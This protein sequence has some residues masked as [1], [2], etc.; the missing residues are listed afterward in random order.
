L[1]GGFAGV[2]ARGLGAVA[3]ASG[4]ARVGNK[5]G[6]TVLTLTLTRW[7]SHGPASPQANDQGVGARKEENNEEKSAPKKSKKTEEGDKYLIW[8][9][10]RNGRTDNFTLAVYMQFLV[11][12]DMQRPGRKP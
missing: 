12:A 5:E 8:G 2:A 11:A 3:L 1:A 4:A 7:T 6:L 10:R 9:R